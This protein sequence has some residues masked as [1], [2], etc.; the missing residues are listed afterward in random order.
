MSHDPLEEHLEA[1][2]VI[3]AKGRRQARLLDHEA[4][5]QLGQ[6]IGHRRYGTRQIVGAD[7]READGGCGFSGAARAHLH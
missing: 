2:L 3:L 6:R 5:V 1:R 4:P 7:R